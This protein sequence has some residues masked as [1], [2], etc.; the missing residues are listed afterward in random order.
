[1]KKYYKD[2]KLI[3]KHLPNGKVRQ[4]VKYDGNY[5]TCRLSE[6][7][8]RKK[9]VYYLALALCSNA[10]M[11]GV[12]LLNTSGSRVIYVALPYVCLFI[13]TFFCLM[14][15]LRF[16]VVGN[17]LEYATYDKS[18]NRIRRSTIGQIILSSVVALGDICY[19]LLSDN[20]EKLLRELFFLGGMILVLILSIRFLIIQKTI[21]YEIEESELS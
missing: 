7:E 12:G 3:S 1:M 5:Y 8:L 10:T 17:K 16:M 18:R 14:G 13:P 9:K 21:I 11:L 2:Y 20:I 15:V 6:T 4:E 19:L